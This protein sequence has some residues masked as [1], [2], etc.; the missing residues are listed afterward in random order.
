M[1]IVLAFAAAALCA[2][3]VTT[4]SVQFQPQAEQQAIIR[5]GTP[6]LVS[7]RKNSL[8]IVRPAARQ[9][10][11]GGRPVFVLAI[12]NRTRV[13]QNFLVSNVQVTQVVSG[14]AVP[15]KVIT[16]EQL[17]EEEHTR[18]V[19][20]AVATGLAAGANAYSASRA[21]YYNSNS[22]VYTPHGT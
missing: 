2:G 16:Y 17:V 5:D 21:G 20:V 8:V 10:Q 15:L 1:R 11:I 22:T 13:P 12:Y 3:C 7:Q 6:A 9:L 14:E 18:Q 4:E 19:F